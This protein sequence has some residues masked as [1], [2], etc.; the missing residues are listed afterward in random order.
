[1]LTK[2]VLHI[3]NTDYELKSDDLKNWDEVL[4]S[5]KRSDYDGV[6]RSFTS[7]FDFVNRAY[8]LIMQAYLRDG[9]NAHATL[10]LYTI[11][12]RWEWEEQFSVPID[13][14]SISWDGYVLRANCLDNSLAALIKARKSTK[15]EFVVGEDIPVAGSLE[16]DRIKMLNSVSHEITDN[17]GSGFWGVPGDFVFLKSADKLTN[18]PT[19]TINSETYEN[20]PISF[21]DETED[22]GSHFLRIEKKV[23]EIVIS[24]DITIYPVRGNNYSGF[25]LGIYGLVPDGE[26]IACGGAM[27][28][29]G[30][31]ETFEEL[32]SK[33][34]QPDAF[35]WAIVC[36]QEDMQI[37]PGEDDY[38]NYNAVYIAPLIMTEHGEMQTYWIKDDYN[39]GGMNVMAMPSHRCMFTKSYKSP[40]IGTKIALKYLFKA[41]YSTNTVALKS[42]I[43]TSWMSRAKPV[44]I[45]S[46]T[47]KDV[48]EALIS[49]MCDYSMRVRTYFDVSDVRVLKTRLFAGESIRDI[50]GAK[51]YS[52]FSDF[53]KWMATVFGY[54]YYLD[55]I[56]ESPYVGT[57][58]YTDV[59]QPINESGFTLIKDEIWTGRCDAVCLIDDQENSVCAVKADGKYYTKWRGDSNVSEWTEY[60]DPKTGCPLK[61]KVFTCVGRVSYVFDGASFVQFMYP[62]D[63][64]AK[65]LQRIHF[66][67]RHGL[68]DSSHIIRIAGIKDFRYTLTN[69][70]IYSTVT[71]GYDKQEYDAQCG[72]DEWNFSA[73]FVTGVDYTDKKTEFTSKYRAD[74]YGFE[75]LAQERAKDTT[76]NKSDSTVFFA[77]CKMETITEGEGDDAIVTSKLVI[78]RSSNV[79]GALTDTVFNGEYAPY[80]CILANAGF[81]SAVKNNITLK[82]ASFDGNTNISIDGVAGNDDV[83]CTSQL[84]TAGEIE[85]TTGEIDTPIDTAALYEME[86]HGVIYRGY[87]KE[88]DIKYAKTEAVKFK[89]IVKDIE[90]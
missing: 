2:Y 6:V 77:H 44:S 47:P 74:C 41:P 48:A 3:D 90:Q 85:F 73:Q 29:L 52:T 83:P 88:V 79:V 25:K 24:A 26:E 27:R 61:D 62:L 56:E 60:N 34:P 51:F 53:C 35:M 63:D 59:V 57:E 75:F 70:L 13:F 20:S 66:L 82:F 84:F 67:P 87:I 68:Y 38:K 46:M 11:T 22:D 76:D 32:E 50:P 81:I 31:F 43:T 7:Q 30:R 86:H 14:S 78:D 8:D 23:D 89:L 9:L 10:T 33:Y 16:Y 42:R 54:T 55:D 45:N 18:A 15:Y 49:K 65:P 72:R 80:K 5:Y 36:D 17:T 58:P 71:V 40:A 39:H 69:D 64:Y 19:Y 4:C 28:Y 12:D 1:M 37:V 21:D